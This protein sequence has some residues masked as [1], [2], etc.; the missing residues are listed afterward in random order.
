MKRNL[1]T[2]FFV[3]AATVGFS[4]DFKVPASFDPQ[5]PRDS[6]AKYQ[7]DV[8]KAV[9]W[10]V[11]NSPE[12]PKRQ[13]A[14]AFLIGWLTG[15]PDVTLE[16]NA[17]ILTFMEDNSQLLPVFMGG[18]AKYAL[19]SKDNDTVKGTVAGINTTLAFYEKYKSEIGKSKGLDAY[20]KL[21]DN[22]KLESTI[23]KKLK[24]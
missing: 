21:R 23:K 17:D 7:P 2:L 9:D 16:I 19:E 12:H 3:L 15:S 1:F 5:G 18:W 24:A 10:L 13:Q 8:L 6:F 14:N 22:G 4:Q 20:A 11:N